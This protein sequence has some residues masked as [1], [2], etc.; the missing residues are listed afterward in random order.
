MSARWVKRCEQI[1]EQIKVLETAKERDRLD[2]VHSLRFG[3]GT[4]WGSLEGWMQW[5][6]SPRIMTQFT[7]EELKKMNSAIMDFVKSF[8]EYDIKMTEQGIKKGFLESIER[9]PSRER[10]LPERFVI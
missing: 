2:I 4:L 8:I 3:L 10:E 6:N 1:L 9:R 7:Q 5:I